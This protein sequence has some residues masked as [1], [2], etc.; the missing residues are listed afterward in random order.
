MRIFFSPEYSNIVYVKPE[1]GNNV[2]MDSVVVNT[3]GLINMLELRMGLHYADMPEQERMAHYYDAV[4]K[5]MAINPDNVM[6]NSFKVSGLS[7]AKSMLAWRDELRNAKWNFE[8]KDISDRISVLIGVEEYFKEFNGIDISD[9][10][11]I[12]TEQ[13]SFQK[14]DCKDMTITMA[15]SKDLLKP[16]TKELINVLENNGAKIGIIANASDSDNNLSKVRQLITSKQKG[17]I[18]LEK[19]DDSLQIWKF[20]DDRLAC[21]YLAYNEMGDVDVWVNT[22]NKQMDNWMRLMDRAL[23]GSVTADCTPHL[24]QLFVMGLGMWALPLNVNNLIEWLN[25]PVHPIDSFFRSTLADTI[26]QQGGY[27]NDSCRKEI[28]QF[29]EGKF[30]YLNDEQK[31][32]PEEEQEKIRQKERKRREKLVAAFLPPQYSSPTIKKNDVRQF[33]TELSS[34]SRQRAHLIAN[35]KGNEQ[36]GEQQIAVSNMCDAFNILLETINDENIDYKTIDSWMSTIYEKGNYTNAVAERGCRTVV[37]SPSKIACAAEKVVWIGVDGDASQRQECAFLY[38]SEKKKLV[39][40]GYMTPWDEEIQNAYHEQMMMTPLRMAKRQLILVVRERI[41]GE[42]TLKHPLIVR[43]EQ[44]VENMDDFVK[45][46]SIGAEERYNVVPIEKG[47]VDA[48][49]HFDHADKIKWPDHLSPTSIGTLAEYPFDY[50][51]EELLKIT[52]DGKSQMADL[53]TTTGNVAHAV[54]EELFAPRDGSG[55]AKPEDIAER[56]KNEYESAYDK[57]LESKGA[58]LQLPENKFAEQ[59]FHEQLRNCLYTLLEILRE[60]NLKVTGCE[61][62]VETNMGLGLPQAID[63]DGNIKNR[64]MIGNI[65]MTLEDKDHHPVVFDFKW[66]SWGKGYQ[67]KLT[68]NRSVQL[69]L[70]RMMLGKKLKDEVKRVAYFIMP[71]GRLYSQEKFEGG[72]CMQVSPENH[73]DI[74]TQLTQAAKYRKEQIGKGIIETNGNYDELQ[75]V[76]DTKDRGLFPLKKTEDGKK[77]S[78]FFSQYGLFNN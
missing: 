51:M 7:T 23:T 38:P 65:D 8:G 70:Y 69:E 37:D 6:A 16:T 45:H 5:Y 66:T 61:R 34:W 75:Y 4:C 71:E 15:V 25:M 54:I 72:Q 43:L 10:L 21:E 76:K 52:S 47:E 68:E 29:I 39:Q 60:N 13:V 17:K 22:D 24:T 74:V 59:L 35:E 48:E 1:G 41:G 56:I 78:N 36:W 73:D 58:V 30:V 3:I 63:K 14:L 62:H 46:P 27:K 19:E 44:Q 40:N 57:I 49:L 50:M 31:A 2:M 53:K 11:H 18:K 26:I 28:E 9:R 77:E 20:A 32:L 55:Y 42:A 64:D 12:A 33:V 67:N